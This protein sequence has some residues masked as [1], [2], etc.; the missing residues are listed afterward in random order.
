MSGFH[1]KLGN[2]CDY[3]S[4]YISVDNLMFHLYFYFMIVPLGWV[5][6]SLFALYILFLCVYLLSEIASFP[7]IF[8]LGGSTKLDLILS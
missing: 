5:S 8:I 4:L 3:F 7:H 2:M 1:A 6:C